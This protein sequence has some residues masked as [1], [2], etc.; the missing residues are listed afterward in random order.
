MFLKKLKFRKVL[1]T[2]KKKRYIITCILLMI[3]CHCACI[4]VYD[5]PCLQKE[6]EENQYM[7]GDQQS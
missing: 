1:K 3:V 4:A 6:S 7:R 2:F 5:G